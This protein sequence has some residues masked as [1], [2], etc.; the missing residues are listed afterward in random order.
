MDKYC[1]WTYMRKG[2]TTRKKYFGTG[3]IM[4]AMA[5]CCEVVQ[6]ML[7]YSHTPKELERVWGSAVPTLLVK[8]FRATSLAGL[9]WRTIDL[10]VH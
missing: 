7:V 1:V 5:C 6:P 3:G 8:I 2:S 4:F 9:S 10:L